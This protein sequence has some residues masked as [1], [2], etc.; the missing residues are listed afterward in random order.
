MV[1]ASTCRSCGA[2]ILWVKTANGKNMPVDYDSEIEY[3][4]NDGTSVEFDAGL[5][6]SHFATCPEADRHR[7]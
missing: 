5:M 2:E 1:K 7:K 6:T 4:W 3:L